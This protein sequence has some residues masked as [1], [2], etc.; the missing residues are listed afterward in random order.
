MGPSGYYEWLQK[1]IAVRQAQCIFKKA[2]HAL[3]VVSAKASMS[4]KWSWELPN[5]AQPQKSSTQ[6][7]LAPLVKLA[8]FRS[9]HPRFR[10]RLPKWTKRA[11]GP[12]WGSWRSSWRRRGI[13]IDV[14]VALRSKGVSVPAANGKVL[15]GPAAVVADDVRAIVRMHKGAVLRERCGRVCHVRMG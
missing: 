11:T 7:T 2:K 4:G 5:G 6:E 9:R 15:V 1:P 3:G 12:R 13:L 14:A 8:P 10:R